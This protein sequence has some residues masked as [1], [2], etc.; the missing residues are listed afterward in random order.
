MLEAIGIA[1]NVV[2][3][4]RILVN[5]VTTDSP[6]SNGPFRLQP[7]LTAGIWSKSV[8]SLVAGNELPRWSDTASALRTVG[9]NKT[10]CFF[11]SMVDDPDST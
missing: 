4:L 7:L 11:G 3:R 10:P 5:V 8:T 9:S 1:F 2:S 6:L